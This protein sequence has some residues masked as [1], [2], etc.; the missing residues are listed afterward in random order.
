[1]EITYQEE[2]FMRE[3]AMKNLLYW[4]L[5]SMVIF[6]GG[7]CSYYLVMQGN[8][9]WLSFQLPSTFFFSTS[10]I[11]F[12]SATMLWAQKS[13]QKGQNRNATLGLFFTL[14][15]GFLFCATQFIAWSDLHSHGIV[16]SGKSSNISGSILYVITFLHFLHIIAGIIALLVT[17]FKV[18]R[19]RY[20]ERSHL[21]I[22]LC[23]IFWHFL[24]VLWVILFLLLYFN[25]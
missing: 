20:S 10:V 15:L 21:G 13:I 17:T 5:A 6:F 25:R 8:G 11:V 14:I 1:M 7:F 23:A 3:K 2:V 9:S 4:S 18:S 22:S 19:N 16:F 24:D 12:S